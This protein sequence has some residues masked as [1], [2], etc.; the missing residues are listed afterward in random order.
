MATI[1][2][3]PEGAFGPTNNCVGI[4]QVP[5]ATGPQGRVRDRGV[6][7]RRARGEGLRGAADAAPAA[8]RDRR[9]A[10]PVLEG[11]H[12]RHRARL[13]TGRRSSSSRASSSRPG[14]RSST[15]RS[16]WTTACAR[17][18]KSVC[19]D[20]IVEDNVVGFSAVVTADCPWVRIVSCNPLELP[21]PELP[22]VFSGYPTD[23]SSGWEEF[24]EEYRRIH[25]DLHADFDEFMRERGCPPLPELEFIHRSPHLNLF[26][27]PEEADYERSRPLGP[28]V[29]AARLVRPQGGLG[30][31]PAPEGRRQARVPEPRQPRLGRRGADAAARGPAGR[32]RLPGDREQGPAARP[33]RAARRPGGAPSS[34]PSPRCCRWSTR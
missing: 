1:V 11:L 22:P 15:A 32:G 27:Y 31:L 23:D 2:F 13:Q 28:D 9:G 18:S 26:L 30:R 14:R 17:S 34:C 4:G 29:G 21:D 19:P 12:P 25:A 5:E 7:R 20:V 24:R 33:D 16:T 8:G 6:V 3:F 10:R